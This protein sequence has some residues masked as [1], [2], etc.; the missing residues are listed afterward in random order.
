M[1]T[2]TATAL[3][4]FFGSYE[5][6]QALIIIIAAFSSIFIIMVLGFKLFGNKD[7]DVSMSF[8]GLK[9][10]KKKE[11]KQ[12]TP[13]PPVSVVVNNFEGDN[14]ETVPEEDMDERAKLS[15]QA[16]I[17]G[18]PSFSNELL[19]IVSKCIR[20]GI[21][22]DKKELKLMRYQMNNAQVKVDNI[23]NIFLKEYTDKLS[24]YKKAKKEIN[25]SSYDIFKEFIKM[26]V[27]NKILDEFRRA[28]KENHLTSYTDE[29]FEEY[30]CRDHIKRMIENLRLEI[31]NIMP[32][33][34][35]PGTDE[36][37]VILD[38]N[39]TSFYGHLKD[40]FYDARV[41]AVKQKEEFDKKE[42]AF[43]KEILKLTGIK[44]ISK[45]A[46]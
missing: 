24:V 7:E 38:K 31:M 30:Y 46:K 23:I 28:F 1:E 8:L 3:T 20:F 34:I 27:T 18:T 36:I 42:E 37:V 4:S 22:I 43:D 11:E 35:V 17:E 44:E 29:N 5:W 10:N 14:E 9:L 12:T 19:L 15:L 32:E 13:A 41:E 21:D 6:W 26:I 2:T 45:R 40:T 33:C 39:E 16:C 25:V